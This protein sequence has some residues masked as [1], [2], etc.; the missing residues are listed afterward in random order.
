MWKDGS[1]SSAMPS[2]TE[3]LTHSPHIFIAPGTINCI[4]L[5][6]FS[7]TCS[8]LQTSASDS[9]LA[10]APSDE[11]SPP[12]TVHHT[13]KCWTKNYLIVWQPSSDG[14][15]V[16]GVTSAPSHKGRLNRYLAPFRLAPSYSSPRQA[17]H[18]NA[19]SSRTTPFCTRRLHP[20][21]QSTAPL[22][23]TYTRQP[24]ELLTPFA[25]S[26]H[27]FPQT[28]RQLYGTWQRLIA[29]SQLY[30]ANGQGWW[31]ASRAQTALQWTPTA[32]LDWLRQ[33][34]FTESWLT[35]AQTF[36][37]RWAWVP[38][39]NGWMTISSSGS[40][41]PTSQSTTGFSRDGTNPS[42]RTGD[43]SKK[44]EDYGTK[45]QGC[46]MAGQRSSTRTSGR[47]SETFQHALSDHKR[48]CYIPTAWETLIIY[49]RSWAFHGSH[50]RTS[51]SVP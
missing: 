49:C 16:K 10:S 1:R 51:P 6:L 45:G 36:S 50:P 25:S 2:R 35:R 22:T 31:Y 46:L 43:E 39:P 40:A 5:A 14:S 17:S 15:L 44:G 33:V 12:L 47:R 7:N 3:G 34:A 13:K 42:K 37:G 27:S 20:S 28:L 41:S 18:V 8:F 24:G 38:Y 11:P 4:A 30:P 26:L 9:T 21:R 23:Q 32:A 29:L 48:T 19:A